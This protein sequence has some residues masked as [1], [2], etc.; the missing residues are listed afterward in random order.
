MDLHANPT[1]QLY[2]AITP[3][4]TARPNYPRLFS[5]ESV[6]ELT[7]EDLLREL[8]LVLERRSHKPLAED[9]YVYSVRVLRPAPFSP[10]A[11]LSELISD[12]PNAVAASA[13]AGYLV[14]DGIYG[15]LAEAGRVQPLIER[16]LADARAV[17]VKVRRSPGPEKTIVV[18]LA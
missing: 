14:H 8:Q 16:F 12:L 9:T 7:R 18:N 1:A 15:Y 13:R 17:E 5:S 10:S 4:E 3:V 6:I 11:L 2:E